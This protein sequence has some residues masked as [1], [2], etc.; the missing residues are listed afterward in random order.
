MSLITDHPLRYKLANELH[1]RPFPSFRAPGVVAY[2]ALKLPENAAGRDRAQDRLDL[3]ALLDRYGAGHP[4]EGATHYFGDLGRYKIKWEQHTE[5]VTYTVFSGALSERAFDPAVFDAFPADW[6]AGL[7][8]VRVTSISIRAELR[9]D[10][11]D[12]SQKLS[13]WFVS[14]SVAV[15][16]VLDD[17]AIVAADFRIDE[18]GHQRVAIFADKDTGERRLGRIIQRLCEIETYKSLSMQGFATARE[19]QGRMG[20]IDAEITDL[21]KSLA[22][23][24]QPAETTLAAVLRHSAELESLDAQ[25]AFRFGATWAYQAIVDQRIAVLREERFKGRQTFYEFMMRRYDPAMRTRQVDR[26]ATNHIGGIARVAP[27]N[28]CEPKWMWNDRRKTKPCWKAWINAPTF[29][30]VCKKQLKVSLSW[31]SAIMPYRWL[32]IWPTPWQRL[33]E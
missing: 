13:D 10:E 16:R 17:S 26:N 5:F 11:D 27:A 9:E 6:L 21:M 1:A 8:A 23:A 12:I 18:T 29:N 28:C 22:E 32:G 15:S 19:I 2:L 3:I 4:K 25:V 7:D 31:R 24:T 20:Q 30:C 14:E 33:S